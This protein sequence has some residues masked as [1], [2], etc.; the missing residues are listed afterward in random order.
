ML[1][2]PTLM[3]VHSCT[4]VQASYKFYGP[5]KI[6]VIS[7][8]WISDEMICLQKPWSKPKTLE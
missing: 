1:L 6:L 7:S 4:F 2:L 5:F 8:Q 3:V